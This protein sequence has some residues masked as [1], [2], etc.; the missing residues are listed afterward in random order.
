MPLRERVPAG[1]DDRHS[2][3]PRNIA[4][5]SAIDRQGGWLDMS[6]RSGALIYYV[7]VLDGAGSVWGVRVP[8]IPG[9]VGGV[10]TAE[11][12]IADAAEA[13]RDVAAHKRVT[14]L[15]PLLTARAVAVED[16]SAHA[17][18]LGRRWVGGWFF[19]GCSRRRLSRREEPPL[20][21]GL[22]WGLRAAAGS[23]GRRR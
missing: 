14:V 9:C 20:R 23:P 12:A 17:R 2:P 1:E 4:R 15:T 6:Q 18:W 13:L 5:R 8:D 19:G 11:A 21:R 22:S 16:G 10:A 7:G 3:P